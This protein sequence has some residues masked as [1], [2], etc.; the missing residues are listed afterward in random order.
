MTEQQKL[1]FLSAFGQE[2]SEAIAGTVGWENITPQDGYEVFLRVFRQEPTPRLLA[3][4]S[5]P[6]LERL[7]A[8]CTA[9]FENESISCDLLRMAITRTLARYP[10]EGTAS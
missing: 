7:L 6:E 1:D 3:A 5:G 9:Y 8:G 4:I 10:S 2:F